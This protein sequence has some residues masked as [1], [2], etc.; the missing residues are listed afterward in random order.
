MDS[1]FRMFRLAG[2]NLLAISLAFNL[3]SL[4]NLEN[5]KETRCGQHFLERLAQTYSY[6]ERFSFFQLH[7][8]SNQFLLIHENSFELWDVLKQVSLSSFQLPIP[9][10]AVPQTVAALPWNKNILLIRTH[11]NRRPFVLDLNLKAIVEGKR[12]ALPPDCEK[13]LNGDA[14]LRLKAYCIK[15]LEGGENSE[16]SFC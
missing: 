16:I 10:H 2:P 4:Y 14:K 11:L 1:D 13:A 8:A 7:H 6:A 5:M 3:F 15:P 12:F 9:T